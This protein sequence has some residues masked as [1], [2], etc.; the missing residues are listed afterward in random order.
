[1]QKLLH[2]IRWPVPAEI[3]LRK[4]PISVESTKGAR[5]VCVL[6]MDR[7]RD[8]GWIRIDE[9]AKRACVRSQNGIFNFHRGNTD[10]E[11]CVSQ[12][13]QPEVCKP[14]TSIRWYERR[15][16]GGHGEKRT[17]S[18]AW[19]DAT[20]GDS[21]KDFCVSQ[22]T[23]L[24]TVTRANSSIYRGEEKTNGRPRVE[25]SGVRQESWPKQ[26]QLRE[27]NESR[28]KSEITRC[29]R[30]QGIQAHRRDEAKNAGSRIE[31]NRSWRANA[32]QNQKARGLTVR[33]QAEYK[34]CLGGT[35]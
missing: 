8:E 22:I 32:A 5:G 34:E 16:H 4:V 23:Q 19:E 35:Q 9:H 12:V 1:M 29:W 25:K 14:D 24:E 30:T 28:A 21:C 6:G 33:R 18:M 26:L 11:V 13:R 3:L 17:G 7:R 10:R 2:N 20:G 31:S 15:E 27:T